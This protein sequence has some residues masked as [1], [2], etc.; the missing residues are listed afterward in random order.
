MWS[1]KFMAR[2]GMKGYPDLLTGA[3][4]ILSDEAEKIVEKVISAL[5]L[6]NFTAYNELI[7]AQ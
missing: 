6:L 3:R 4:K 1:G 7:L 5:K 2:T